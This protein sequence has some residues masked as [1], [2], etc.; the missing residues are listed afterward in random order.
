[1]ILAI[2]T[3]LL[4]ENFTAARINDAGFLAG[5]TANRIPVLLRH[6]RNEFLL[7][8]KPR[9]N[10]ARTLYDAREHPPELV[11]VPS[12]AVV[13]AS[14]AAKSDTGQAASPDHGTSVPCC[15]NLTY[16]AVTN[17]GIVTMK[18]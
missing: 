17:R 8:R 11:H 3:R 2:A 18:S 14:G 15:R 13:S 4:A 16:W 12:W 5:T 1:V 7:N 9:H 6:Y 10:P